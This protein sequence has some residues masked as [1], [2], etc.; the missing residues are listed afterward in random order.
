MLFYLVRLHLMTSI[1]RYQ[2]LESICSLFA[3]AEP[4]PLIPNPDCCS[5]F[6]SHHSRRLLLERKSSLQPS[7]WVRNARTCRPGIHHVYV[8]RRMLSH[9]IVTLKGKVSSLFTIE[10]PPTHLPLLTKSCLPPRYGEGSAI[11]NDMK[12]SPSSKCWM[13]RDGSTQRGSSFVCGPASRIK[14]LSEG[15]AAARRPATMHAVVPPRM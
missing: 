5:L 11:W 8:H 1:F 10:P 3:T 9:S 6:P 7:A 4:G 14:I 13:H 12:G 2:S 15:S